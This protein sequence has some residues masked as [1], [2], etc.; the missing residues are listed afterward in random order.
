MKKLQIYIRLYKHFLLLIL[1]IPILACF[2]YCEGTVVPKH[3]MYS[4]L[5]DY[6]PFIKEFVIFYI[7][8]YFYI[9]YG[10]IYIGF[11]SKW[12]FFKLLI[13]LFGGMCTSYTIYLVYPNCQNLRPNF[14]GSDI[15]SSIIKLL[16]KIDTPT[17]VFPSLHVFNAIAIDSA[18][19]N[20]ASFREK[21]LGSKISFLLMLLIS[22]STVFIKQHS[23]VDTAAGVLLGLLFYI[24]LYFLQKMKNNS[25]SPSEGKSKI[26]KH[27]TLFNK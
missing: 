20:N 27:L 8:W 2:F 7:A 26:H 12:D 23:I 17:N 5:D 25:T 19:R 15:F 18:L 11:K 10:L 22:L 3:I 13:F 14:T 6:I 24:P 1:W 4:P 16:Y 21:P 9:A